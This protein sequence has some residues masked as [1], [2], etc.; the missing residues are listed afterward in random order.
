MRAPRRQRVRTVGRPS[1]CSP[2]GHR[3]WA[4]RA[5][6]RRR[7][8]AV[9]S[10]S[11]DIPGVPLTP[12][13]V[14]GPWAEASTTPSTRS[15]SQQGSVI[16]ASLSGTSGTDFDL[17]LFDSS[18][19]TVVTNQG[20]VARSTG[21]TSTESLSY[22]TSAGGRFYIDLN[23]A[24]AAV[25]TYTLVVQVVADRP[26]VATGRPGWGTGKTNSPTVSVAVS[27]SGGL[28]S[29]SRMAFSPDGISWLP[30]AAYQPVDDPGRFPTATGRRPCGLGSRARLVSYPG[31][32][33]PASSS[34]PLVRRWSP[35]THRSTAT[36]WARGRQSP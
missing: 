21:P 35:W 18:A 19:T 29:A 9:A 10:N 36:S 24:T 32:S 13:V 5:H 14:V 16:L 8:G 28:S 15:T 6:G 34:T 27:L 33:R 17:Y 20:V 4:S 2:A 25:G 1:A 3:R 30:W 22:W 23:S 11:S 12:G 31:P 26:A 7:R